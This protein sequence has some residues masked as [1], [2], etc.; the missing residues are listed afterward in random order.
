MEELIN[1][2]GKGDGAGKVVFSIEFS[3]I[4]R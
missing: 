2:E 4:L 3:F 1:L